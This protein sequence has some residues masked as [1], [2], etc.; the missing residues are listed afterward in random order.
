MPQYCHTLSERG[1]DSL[2]DFKRNKVPNSPDR[3]YNLSKILDFNKKYF[4]SD[5]PFLERMHR[6]RVSKC[7]LKLSLG[8]VWNYFQQQPENIGNLIEIRVPPRQNV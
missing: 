2:T 8:M 5:L 7:V 4:C 3:S 1:D 6:F